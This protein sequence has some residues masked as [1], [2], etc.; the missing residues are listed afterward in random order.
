MGYTTDFEGR[1]EIEPAL[2][3]LEIRYLIRFSETRRMDREK[4]PYFI[5][6]AGYAGQDCGPDEIYNYNKP[7]SSQPGL[8]C[9]WLP[10][11]DG[12]ALVWNG[13]EKFYEAAAWMQY[14]MD[15]FVGC[16]PAAKEELRE[17][18]D[19]GDFLQGHV[20]NGAI[21]AQ[22]EEPSD[23]W[24]LEVKDNQVF[25]QDLVLTT[26]GESV[27]VATSKAKQL[28][29]PAPKQLTRV[30]ASDGKSVLPESGN[31]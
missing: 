16:V 7:H 17:L 21:S 8:W 1:I 12:T 28:S 30:A 20:C 5:G 2:N 18:T 24:L 25:V 15:H 10:T 14:L 31:G 19:V 4:G 26:S 22:G 23:M 13:A 11:E 27:P 29:A 9:Q 6:G 3:D